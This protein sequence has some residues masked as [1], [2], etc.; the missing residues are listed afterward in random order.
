MNNEINYP[1]INLDINNFVE[2]C[3]NDK[4]TI[5]RIFKKYK[6]L[7]YQKQHNLI[8]YKDGGHIHR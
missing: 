3:G 2:E 7:Y 4:E 5:K 8:G 1:L 6:D